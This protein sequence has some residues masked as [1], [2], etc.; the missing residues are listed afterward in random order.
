MKGYR[1]RQIH[2]AEAILVLPVGSGCAHTPSQ[3]ASL[4]SAITTN[5]LTLHDA[6]SMNATKTFGHL[7]ASTVPRKHDGGRNAVY[8]DSRDNW[9]LCLAGHASS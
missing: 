7:C 3:I 8:H 1:Y 9:W 6:S 5:G 2:T 4:I